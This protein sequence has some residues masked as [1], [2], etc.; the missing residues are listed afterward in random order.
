[1]VKTVLVHGIERWVMTE[2]DVR[3]LNT[4]MGEENIKE[5]IGTSG[6]TRNM[7]DKN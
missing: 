2:M 5:D 3:T 7:K 4:Y 1:M 6:R